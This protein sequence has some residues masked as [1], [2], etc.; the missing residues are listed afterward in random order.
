MAAMST[1]STEKNEARKGLSRAAALPSGRS[2]F[3]PSRI[4]TWLPTWPLT[5]LA[6]DAQRL[7]RED[8]NRPQI[9]PG[10]DLLHGLLGRV[11]VDP[12]LAR[13][14][15][16]VAD[17]DQDAERDQD[18]AQQ[19]ADDEARGE[20]VVVEFLAGDVKD[21]NLVSGR[22]GRMRTTPSMPKPVYCKVYARPDLG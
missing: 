22:Q 7:G 8:E 2:G 18:E 12:V 4:L 3:S 5:P 14:V 21:H 13:L 1:K 6:E 15:A 9:G 16:V 11:A 20:E 17:A 10:P 19:E